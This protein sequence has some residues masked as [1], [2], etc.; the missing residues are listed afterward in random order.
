MVHVKR[1]QSTDRDGSIR[2]QHFTLACG[3]E[4]RFSDGNACLPR[5]LTVHMFL[6]FTLTFVAGPGFNFSGR[7]LWSWPQQVRKKI[8]RPKLTQQSAAKN[9]AQKKPGLV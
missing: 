7:R 3:R 2:L 8:K 5:A 1:T 9:G 4:E 6:K